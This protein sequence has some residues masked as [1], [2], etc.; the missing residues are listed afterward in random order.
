MR[1][2]FILPLA[3]AVVL[4]GCGKTEETPAGSDGAGP[5]GGKEGGSASAGKIVMPEPGEYSQTVEVLEISIP[6]MPAGMTDQV[7]KQMSAN[8]SATDCLTPEE[9]KDALKVLTSNG[10]DKDSECNYSKF[11]VSGGRLDAVMECGKGEG[12]AKGTF[13]LSGTFTATGSDITVQGDQVDP[14]MPGGKMHLK[15]HAVS[16][17]TGEC[18][19]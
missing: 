3:A 13:T 6:G 10:V 9:A 15:M 2:L 11:D 18:K 12:K 1:K 19:A 16:V 4:A 8:M 7:K 5:S 17:R 14:Q